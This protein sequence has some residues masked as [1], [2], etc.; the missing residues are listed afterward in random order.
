MIS[1]AAANPRSVLATD[2]RSFAVPDCD[3]NF[4][5][6]SSPHATPNAILSDTLD[7]C[8]CLSERGRSPGGN[9]ASD[10]GI[11]KNRNAI[12]APCASHCSVAF[13]VW[14]S[15]SMCISLHDVDVIQCDH[16]AVR[17]IEN[18][19]CRRQ[20]GGQTVDV[21]IVPDFAN[22]AARILWPPIN[23]F[24]LCNVRWFPM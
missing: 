11:R 24:A 6:P 12:S 23:V 9:G 13:L 1:I 7:G 3:S 19:K 8:G 2:S 18:H 10:L 4:E 22:S 20:I 5:S 17:I 21:Q 14:S 15:S 16:Q